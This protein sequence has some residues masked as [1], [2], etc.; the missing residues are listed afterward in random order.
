MN[1]E[2][3]IQNNLPNSLDIRRNWSKHP[4]AYISNHPSLHRRQCG[5]CSFVFF[6]VKDFFAFY[7]RTL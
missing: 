1:L 3:R 4:L 2:S 7:I 6:V 5:V